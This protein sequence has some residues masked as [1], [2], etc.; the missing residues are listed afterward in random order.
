MLRAQ[1]VILSALVFRWA[2]ALDLEKAMET[3]RVM[4]L[5]TDLARG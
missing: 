4:G 2:S 1:T 5:E 3:A